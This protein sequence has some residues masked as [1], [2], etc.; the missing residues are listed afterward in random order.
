M[1]SSTPLRL[2]A[3]LL[4]CLLV[5]VPAEA[6]RTA[7]SD[8]AQAVKG[9]FQA[10]AGKNYAQAWALLSRSSQDQIVT[11]IARDE[12]MEPAAVRSLFERTDPA[13]CNGFW[14]SF[15]NSSSSD[16]LAQGTFKTT[17]NA[18]NRATV[19]LANN[20][21]ARFLAFLENGSW[22][23]GLLETFPPGK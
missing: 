10:V 5:A 7:A 6:T 2:L 20:A 23:F 9:F 11:M 1:T 22:R 15:R 16:V 14:E 12:K 4:L 8:P 19:E 3:A 18:G 21:N 17:Q 13:I